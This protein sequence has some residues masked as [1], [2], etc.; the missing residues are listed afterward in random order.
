MTNTDHRAGTFGARWR[1]AGLAAAAALTV[2]GCNLDVSTPD[3]VA[4]AA[5]RDSSALTTLVAGTSGDFGAA[6]AGNDDL[7]DEGLIL[8]GGL[9]ADEWINRDTFEER[10]DIDLGT[11]RTDNGTLRDLFRNAQRARRSAEFAAARFAEIAPTSA[12]YARVSSFAG[13]TYVL[14]GEHFCSGVPISNLDDAGQFVFGDPL[15]TTQLFTAALAKFDTALAVATAAQSTTQQ[16]LARVGRGR[17]LLNLG[18]YADAAAAVAAVPTS[19]VFEVEF[20]ENA[21]RENNAVFTFNNIRRRWGVANNEGRNGLPFVSASD[22]RV[23]TV[24]STRNGLDGVNLLIVNQLKYPERAANIPVAD[25]IEARLI[26]AEAALN[27][28]NTA[29]FLTIHNA[30]RATES[31]PPLVAVGLSRRQLEDV[32]FR[33]RAFWLFATAHRLGDLRRLV[34]PATAS[35]SQPAGYGRTVAETFPQGT[36]FKSSTPYGAQ[37]SLIIP[38]EEENN[39]KFVGCQEGF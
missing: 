26:E 4:P 33:E 37:T 14:L 39:A 18:R 36:Y 32:H 3:I 25:G 27:A 13:Y 16:H 6:F 30:L 21:A 19:F 7:G 2:S 10:R 20:S 9:R 17:A 29:G 31:L 34:R 5:L 28:G 38:L 23:P 35:P 15:S 8:V 1:L 11:M 22:P 24:T 12:D